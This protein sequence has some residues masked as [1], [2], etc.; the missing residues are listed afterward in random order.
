MFDAII[1]VEILPT[2]EVTTLLYILSC[3]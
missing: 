1:F 3:S 2:I